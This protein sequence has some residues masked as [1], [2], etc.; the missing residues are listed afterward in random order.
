VSHQPPFFLKTLHRDA[1]CY[2]KNIGLRLA[3]FKLCPKLCQDPGGA[4]TDKGDVDLGVFRLERIDRLLRIGI[5][6]A[7]IKYQFARNALRE[8][9]TRKKGGGEDG[10]C[11]SLHGLGS[12]MIMAD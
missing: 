11:Q 6:L 2:Q 8:D 3:G 5:R 4:V 1:V 9:S 7:R 12:S 10:K